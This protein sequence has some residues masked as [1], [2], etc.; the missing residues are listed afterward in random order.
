M[1]LFDH[2][3]LSE[4]SIFSNIDSL[5]PDFVPKLLPHR[6]NKQIYIADCIKPLLQERNGK[7]LLISGDPGIGK[8]A[9][10]KRVLEDLKEQYNLSQVFINCWKTNSSHK[11]LTDMAE[12]LGFKFTINMSSDDL[13]KRIKKGAEKG[14]VFVFDEVDKSM[15]Y[16]FLY[17]ILEEVPKRTIIL[18]TNDTSWISKLDARI[19]SR[20]VPEQMHFDAYNLEETKD[21]LKERIKYSFYERV[22]KEDTLQTVLDKTVEASDIRIGI[23]ILRESGLI[24]EKDASR[25]VLKKHSLEAIGKIKDFQRKDISDFSDDEKTLVDIIK[26]NSGKISGEIYSLYKMNGGTKS[27]RTV[28]RIVRKLEKKGIIELK[29]TG[30]GFKGKSS[31]LIFK[32]I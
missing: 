32:G 25:E 30:E 19:R 11:I 26:D 7:N 15:D 17:H 20:M 22:W 21:I 14:C 10:V 16:D 28:D 6:E 9:S 23:Y 29:A 4:E 18:I 31:I 24:A 27:Q 13:I 2:T 5:D 3:L 12:Q 1:K 8:T